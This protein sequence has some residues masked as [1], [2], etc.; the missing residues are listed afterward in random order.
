M[1]SDV[2]N[3]ERLPSSPVRQWLTKTQGCRTWRCNKLIGWTGFLLKLGRRIVQSY[4]RTS[5]GV[6]L[7]E[8]PSALERLQAPATAPKFHMELLVDDSVRLITMRNLSCHNRDWP[9]RLAHPPLPDF[10]KGTRTRTSSLR[11]FVATNR[12]PCHSVCRIGCQLVGAFELLV[13]RGCPWGV[14]LD[15]IR[16]SL[17]LDGD[18]D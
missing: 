16:V 18:L 15:S 5:L 13:K 11:T 10:E 17:E 7:S 1:P 12:L 6:D 14:T 8:V 4:N 3:C 9:S 2:Q